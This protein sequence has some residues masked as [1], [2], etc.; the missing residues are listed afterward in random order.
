MSGGGA[1]P[2]TG[3]SKKWW[4]QEVLDFVRMWMT[5]QEAE[6]EERKGGED[7]AEM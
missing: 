1:T 2:V 4:D 7:G 6:R 5:A 3:V